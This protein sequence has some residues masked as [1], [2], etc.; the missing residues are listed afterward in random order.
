MQVDGIRQDS[1]LTS[2][3]LILVV[4]CGA[5]HS[6]LWLH[7]DATSQGENLNTYLCLHSITRQI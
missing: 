6:Y 5:V 7:G 2:R 1:V 3:L 4:E